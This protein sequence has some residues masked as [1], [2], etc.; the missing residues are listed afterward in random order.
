[1]KRLFSFSAVILFLSLL[2]SACSSGGGSSSS[3]NN[4]TTTPTKTTTISGKVTLSSSVSGKANGKAIN[5]APSGRPGSKEYLASRRPSSAALRTSLTGSNTAPLDGATVY[6]FDSDHPEWLAPVAETTA[7]SQGNYTFSVLKN[8]AKNE[9]ATYTDGASIPAGKYT[10]VAFKFTLGQKP[11]VATMTIVNSFEGSVSGTDMVAQP[12]DATPEVRTM[13]GFGKNTDGTQTWGNSSAI[14]PTNAAIQISF[15]MAMWRDNLDSITISPAVDGHW[16]L[17]AD[18][19]TATFYPADGVTLTPTTVYTITITGADQATLSVPAVTNVYGNALALTAVGTF[20][21]G[22]AADTTKP[23]GMWLSPSISEMA[24]AVDVTKPIRI[25]SNKVLDVNGLLLEGTPSL[26][27]KPG[28]M[29]V[30]KDSNSLYVYEF[31]LG[32]PL[33]LGTTYELKVS[34][35]KDLAGN[36]MVDL[37]GSLSTMSGQGSEV[38]TGISATADTTTQN[39]Q[40]EVKGV[41]GKWV[42]ALN[43]RN[44]A[45]MQSVMSGDFYMEYDLASQGGIDGGTDVNRDG[46]YSYKEWSDMMSKFAFPQWQYCGTSVTGDIIGVINVV[47][48]NADFEFKLTATSSISSRE[49]SDSGPKDSLYATLQMVNG[50]WTIVRASEG[51][52]TRDRPIVNPAKITLTLKEGSTTVA[53]GGQL[54]TAVLNPT[55]PAVIS[56]NWD[57]TS[58]VSTYVLVLIDKRNPQQGGA[59]ALPSTVTNLSIDSDISAILA[60]L[61]GKDISELLGFGNK[62]SGGDGGGGDKGPFT[63]GAQI[64]WEVIGL[65]SIGTNAIVDKTAA[66]IL[67][68][69]VAISSVNTFSVAGTYKEMTATVKSGSTAL[70]YNEM[71]GGYDAGSAANVTITV[72]TMNEDAVTNPAGGAATQNVCMPGVNVNGSGNKFYPITFT[73]GSATVTVDL[74]QGWNGVDIHDC[75]GLNRYFSVQTTGG[76]APVIQISSVVDDLGQTLTKDTKGNYYNN[77]DGT[78]FKTGGKKVTITG[79]I[80][81][82]ATLANLNVNVWNDSLQANSYTS[83]KVTNNAFTVTTDIYEGDNWINLNGNSNTGTAGTMGEQF[84]INFGVYTDTGTI[85]VPPFSDI[86]VWST[87]TVTLSPIRTYGNSSEWDASDDADNSVIITGRMKKP[88]DGRYWINSDGNNGDGDLKAQADGTFSIT[89]DLYNGMNNVGMNDADG[90]WYGL[91][92]TTT[93]GKTVIKTVINTVNGVA[94]TPSTQGGYGSVSVGAACTVTITGKALVGDMNINWSGYDGNTSVSHW[95][96]QTVQSAGTAGTQGDF[97]VTM[98]LV[99]GTGSYNSVDIND[100]N[101][102]WTGLEVKTTGACPYVDPVMTVTKVN[103]VSPIVDDYGNINYDAGTS[104]TISISGTSNRA[105]RTVTA[106]LY[107][108]GLNQSNSGVASSTANVSG[109]YDWT[110]TGITVYDTS[111]ASGMGSN[112]INISDGSYNNN[113]SVSITS[114]NGSAPTPVLSVAD[115]GVLRDSDNLPAKINA[116]APAMCGNKTWD[117]GNTNSV[118]IKGH[119]SAKVT[120]GMYNDATGGSHTFA[121]DTDGNFTIAN[122][123]VYGSGSIDIPGWNNISIHDSDWNSFNV[124]ISATNTQL[125]PQL[126]KII[127][128][129]NGA[130]ELV[131]DQTVTG[132]IDISNPDFQPKRVYANASV[133]DKVTYMCSNVN[134]SSDPRDQEPPMSNEPLNYDPA[135]GNFSFSVD[136]GLS[137]GQAWISVNSFDDVT[138]V[139]H[140]HSIQVNNQYGTNPESWYKA[141]S[142]VKTGTQNPAYADS[143]IKRQL[144]LMDRSR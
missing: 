24:T 39:A 80:A 95:E 125:K 126:V 127:T 58:S 89:V 27:A 118:T 70:T 52:D 119:T 67:G 111:Q 65:G 84:N 16:T 101:Y 23:T 144:M 99:G 115:N 12:S 143:V 140:G 47:G 2:I 33:K 133:C 20:K 134:F 142:R 139:N 19:T 41:F 88:V 131:S 94:Y 4:G 50:A 97:S 38:V 34:G 42:R 75:A 123:P 44:V 121:I 82:G 26:G 22:S 81:A 135:T 31:V 37:N 98:P 29:Y 132:K 43:D 69:V 1:M 112:W 30:G 15:S 61:G 51:I 100:A 136:F 14:F 18:W 106:T 57:T 9:G 104:A 68:D 113:K 54:S 103:N 3:N 25:G 49:C 11:L 137:A 102:K 122:I 124:A 32:D 128:P 79:T 46:R 83:T 78:G 138:W 55:N 10:L 36:V 48:E 56:F 76:I 114:S 93:A 62:D 116:N 85:Y 86:T 87:P 117:A 59:I 71:I 8:S 64:A 92:I 74:F 13:F 109:T 21:T 66:D 5:R 17:S 120:S 28:I 107:T 90:N 77:P 105:G 35:G 72:H 40:A 129:R 63:P 45:Q 7:D 130:V 60:K 53:N 6:L 73:N 110:I 108:C 91:N 96:S 141:G